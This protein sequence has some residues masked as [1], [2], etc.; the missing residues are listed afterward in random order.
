[1][2]K[3]KDGKI[4]KIRI[5]DEAVQDWIKTLIEEN[6]S[7]QEIDSILSNLNE[8]YRKTKF[9]K[10]QRIINQV[11]ADIQNYV[12][13]KYRVVIFLTK[14]EREDFEK[15]CLNLIQKIKERY[16]KDFNEEIDENSI[17]KILITILKQNIDAMFIF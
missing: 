12:N 4:L 13:Q 1:M 10:E 11:F 8:E 17:Q 2:E 5:P 9:S 15:K 14:E 16:K 6:F 7:Q 3:P